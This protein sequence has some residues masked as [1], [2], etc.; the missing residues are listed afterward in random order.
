MELVT[1]CSDAAAGV[2][3]DGCAGV[4]CWATGAAA[5]GAGVL[6]VVVLSFWEHPAPTAS[7]AKT[8]AT[9]MKFVLMDKCPVRD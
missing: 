5:S 4:D 6:F 9:G 8:V 3:A 1:F 7:K 2:A